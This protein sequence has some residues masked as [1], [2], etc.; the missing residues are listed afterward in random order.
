MSVNRF[1]KGDDYANFSPVRWSGSSQLLFSEQTRVGNDVV[2]G[3]KK[4]ENERKMSSTE[5]YN[6][7]K[8]IR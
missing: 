6:E 2:I 1:G 8:N 7:S 4:E 5:R 3:Y